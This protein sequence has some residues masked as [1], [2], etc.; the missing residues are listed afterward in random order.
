MVLTRFALEGMETL[1]STM[2]DIRR[3]NAELE[4]LGCVVTVLD[5]RKVVQRNVMQH[6]SRHEEARLHPV[7]IRTD[8]SIEEAQVVGEPVVCFDVSSKSS[9]DYLR[10][11]REL[12]EVFDAAR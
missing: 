7:R 10:L 8:K 4:Y 5:T 6:L 1:F 12:E 3:H 11:A 9:K 2:E